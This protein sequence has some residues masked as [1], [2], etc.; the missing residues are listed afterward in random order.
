MFQIILSKNFSESGNMI[1]CLHLSKNF[2]KC[3]RKE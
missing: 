2:W 3:G 1:L